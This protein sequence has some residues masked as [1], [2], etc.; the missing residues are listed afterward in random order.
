MGFAKSDPATWLREESGRR[1]RSICPDSVI[2]TGYE[3][4]FFRLFFDS[5]LEQ[6]LRPKDE[7]AI[8]AEVIALN[9][10]FRSVSLH[11]QQRK[12]RP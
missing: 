7:P 9:V 1:V 3:S 5:E 11:V 12:F 2:G 10:N 4:L 8:S 6:R